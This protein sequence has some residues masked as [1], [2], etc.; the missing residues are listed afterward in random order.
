MSINK[1][2]LPASYAQPG[3]TI[4]WGAILS[5]L[6]FILALGWLLFTLGSAIGLS[7]AEIHTL[8]DDISSKT[9]ALGTAAT[10]WMLA[11]IVATYFLGGFLSGKVS[12]RSDKQT[13]LL[14]GVVLWSC[15]IIIGIIFSAIGVTGIMNAATGAA[16]SVTS[17]GAHA[18]SMMAD[19]ADKDIGSSQLG[20][21]LHPL[22]G[23][24]KQDLTKALE[25]AKQTSKHSQQG[26]NAESDIPSRS[27]EANQ[28]Q[29]NTQNSA[30]GSSTSHNESNNDTESSASTRADG[31][32][33]NR[34]YRDDNDEESSK[35]VDDATDDDAK[36]GRE[37][38]SPS[39]AENDSR[40]SKEK[41]D[42]NTVSHSNYHSAHHYS[43][44]RSMERAIEKIDPQVLMTVAL[45]LIQGD[46]K[47]AKGII[48]S[49]FDIE[50]A[51][52]DKLVNTAKQKAEQAA[53]ELEKRMNEAKDYAAGLLWVIFL[54]YLIGLLACIGGAQLAMRAPNLLDTA[55]TRIPSDK[56]Y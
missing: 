7:I 39:R 28:N 1:D 15:T 40:A 35:V 8:Q 19:G 33:Y 31:D 46:E 25:K 21:F 23:S 12:G 44:S 10:V 37:A 45:A 47:R 2:T 32:S 54:S 41:S 30:E 53:K 55:D 3:L 24:L 20:S 13:G 51:E 52:V 49:H 36:E 43:R 11:T 18:V 16:K 50:E 48:T 4:N 22:T 42:S 27:T 9:T 14:H 6:V 56:K 34:E 5:G 38:Q 17:T 29:S 26:S